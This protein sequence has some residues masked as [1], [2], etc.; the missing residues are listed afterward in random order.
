MALHQRFLEAAKLDMASAKVLTKKDLYQPAIYHL[1]QTYEKCIKS[2]F[3]FKETAIKHT[4]EATVYNNLRS[5]LGHDTE[6]FTIGLL[7]DMADLEKRAAECTLPNISDPQQRHVLAITTKSH[8]D[9]DFTSGASV[10]PVLCFVTLIVSG[11]TDVAEV[12]SY[13]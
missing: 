13:I 5:G 12:S 2:Y 6:G 9:G 4:S 11:G 3:I 10:P 7:K 8:E 1:Q